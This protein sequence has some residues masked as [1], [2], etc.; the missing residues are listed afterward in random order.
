MN[1]PPRRNSPGR[2]AFACLCV[3][4]AYAW[5]LAATPAPTPDL[6]TAF[7]APGGP[8][9]EANEWI[10]A[11]RKP[12]ET[13]GHWYANIGYY[14]HDPDRKAWREGGRLV[15]WHAGTGETTA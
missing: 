2:I 14:A 3:S 9:A 13:D 11:L 8:M 15:R 10:L 6:L 4:L 7:R 5:A 12:N 1:T